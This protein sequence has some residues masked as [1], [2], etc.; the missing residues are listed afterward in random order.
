MRVTDWVQIAVFLGLISVVTPIL[1]RFI[2]RVCLGENHLASRWLRALEKA[3]VSFSGISLV[4]EQTPRS[5]LKSLGLFHLIGAI[6]FL[7]V[8]YL[9]PFFPGGDR[10]QSLSP[11]LALNLTA[12]FLT[13][14]NW[15]SA[16]PETYIHPWVQVLAMTV[17][18]FLSAAAGI[19]VFFCFAR[20][21]RREKTETVGNFWQDLL[22]ALFGILL[23]MSM[24][25]SLGLVRE[26]VPQ[27]LTATQSVHTLENETQTVG[28]GWVA[29]QV[30]IK[31]V[32]SNGGGYFQSNG[33]H[34]LENP[35]P[36][37][38]LM[39]LLAMLLIPSACL[40]AFGFIVK[41]KRQSWMLLGTVFVLM[42]LLLGGAFASQFWAVQN[43]SG[44]AFEGQELRF[45][46]TGSVLWSVV[47]TATSNGSV[48][49]ALSSLS[50]LAGGV[51]LLGI[52]LG[53]VVFG[54]VGVGAIGLLFMVLL[55]VFLA[56]LMVGRSPEYLG[57][58]IE[59]TEVAAVLVSL[60][61]PAGLVLGGLVL[62][63][64]QPSVI[65]SFSIQSPHGLTEAMYALASAAYNNGS[66]FGG[67]SAQNSFWNILLS[68]AM[69][70]GRAAVLVP[71]VWIAGT[72]AEKKNAPLGSGS[73]ATD[74]PL[75][76]ALVVMVVIVVGG[77]TYFPNLLLGPILE[78]F[79][80]PM[81]RWF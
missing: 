73:F 2:A 16:A 46:T 54:G 4:E 58:K 35:T 71:A 36:F 75:F 39:Q 29:S 21:L 76:S 37:S 20:C 32:G 40:Y 59:R 11:D 45:G 31:M 67:L 70:V 17:Q 60:L 80:I 55:T 57:K 24:V 22:R 48:N 72:L 47:T 26:G 1:G 5:Y 50:P 14:T 6:F 27:M 18:N 52:L 61:L 79:L 9:T 69:I 15:Q 62:V 30:S 33:A 49:A 77:L 38:N 66:S 81:G 51:A 23:P 7:A 64:T 10:F 28:L 34:P 8:L 74:T 56:G 3:F 78:H 25:L 41:A 44:F 43:N 42:S 68:V 12:S 63:L 53:E 65:S 13:N 19:A